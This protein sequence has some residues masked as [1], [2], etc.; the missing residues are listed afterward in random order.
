MDVLNVILSMTG[1]LSK[2]TTLIFTSTHSHC[3]DEAI[4][5]RVDELV[6]MGHPLD[7]I[8]RKRLLR[9]ELFKFF[10]FGANEKIP[11]KKMALS[12][13]IIAIHHTG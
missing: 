12:V 7:P 5:D 1:S 10:D 4:L 13:V 2:N 8:Q 11:K 9:R 3:I 6:D